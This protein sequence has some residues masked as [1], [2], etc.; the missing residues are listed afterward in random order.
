M[1]QRLIWLRC[2]PCTDATRHCLSIS[3]W[4]VKRLASHWE[5]APFHGA[6]RVDDWRG[7]GR[8]LSTVAAPFVWRCRNRR[9]L[10]PFPVAAH[11]TGHAGPH[12]ALGQDLRLS[13]SESHACERGGCNLTSPSVSKS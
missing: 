8:Y 5:I 4:P 6:R 13:L 10:T 2:A 7:G 9:T 11:R 1:S 3:S 12:P